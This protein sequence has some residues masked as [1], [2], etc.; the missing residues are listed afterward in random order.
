MS[1]GGGMCNICLAYL[2]LPVFTAA[3]TRAGDY[4]D[5]SAA[6][7]TGETPAT[8]RLYKENAA[9]SGFVLDGAAGG[10]IDHALSIYYADVIETA[11]AALQ[12]AMTESRRLPRFASPIPIVCAGGTT[13]AGNFLAR[14]KATLA[15]TELPVA[16]SDVYL[17]RDPLNATAKG[18]LVGAM[19]NM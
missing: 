15:A 17:A 2:G 5:R 19:L 16:V 6:S 12:T 10:A 9:E 13:M 14:L 1:F 3:T 11:V 4:I 7:V 8:V 18:A